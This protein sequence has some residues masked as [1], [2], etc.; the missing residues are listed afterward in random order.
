MVGYSGTLVMTWLV[1]VVACLLSSRIPFLVF[2]FFCKLERELNT[3]PFFL[4]LFVVVS[5]FKASINR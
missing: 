4:F 1:L 2:F 3:A 5:S